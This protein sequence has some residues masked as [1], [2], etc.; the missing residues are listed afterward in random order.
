MSILKALHEIDFEHA[1]N[2]KRRMERQRAQAMAESKAHGRMGGA[3][4]LP[5][6]VVS[7][8]DLSDTAIQ[9][10]HLA[11]EEGREERRNDLLRRGVAA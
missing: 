2:Q 1:L 10:C 5:L 11:L 8:P 4:R 9:K 7:N 3:D 6:S